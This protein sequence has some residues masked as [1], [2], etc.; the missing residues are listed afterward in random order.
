MDAGVAN[1][2]PVL[3][4]VLLPEYST[5]VGDFVGDVVADVDVD[6]AVDV[7]VVDAFLLLLSF[8]GSFASSSEFKK[9]VSLLTSVL[10][11][12]KRH[13]SNDD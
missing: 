3:K 5:F 4:L 1:Q 8:G 9:S 2:L 7:V 12:D 6:I 10:A 11:E 13:V